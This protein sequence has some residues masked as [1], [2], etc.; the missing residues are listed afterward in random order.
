[1]IPY[2]LELKAR[3]SWLTPIHNQYLRRHHSVF[4]VVTVL[5]VQVASDKYPKC[6]T[7]VTNNN[8]NHV[9]LILEAE[10]EAEA[11]AETK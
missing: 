8:D 3:L 10:A 5:R 9:F 7:A 1:M 2:P 11:E 4:L 6:V